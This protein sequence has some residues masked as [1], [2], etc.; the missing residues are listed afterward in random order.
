MWERRR[1]QSAS[2]GTVRDPVAHFVSN[3]SRS[4][5]FECLDLANES[6]TDERVKAQ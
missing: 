3:G 1:A 2:Q 6:S 5:P 4:I